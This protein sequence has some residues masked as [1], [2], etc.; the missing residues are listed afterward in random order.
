MFER[1]KVDNVS[2]VQTI[3]VP[4]E[5]T[6]DDGQ[7]LRGKF[8]APQGRGVFEMLNGASSFLE[9]EPYGGERSLVAKSTIKA[10]KLV[11]VPTASQLSRRASEIDTFDPFAILGVKAGAPFE[12]VRAAYL[13]LAMIYHPDRY[14]SAE[15]PPE[16]RDYLAAMVRRIN[17]AFAAIEAPHQVVKKATADRAE[18]VYTSPARARA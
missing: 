11:A 10:V 1:A 5:L 2:A 4:V 12:D 16:V 8:F 17:A 3:A 13:R 7:Q 18:A 6:L 15:L 9:F 14:A